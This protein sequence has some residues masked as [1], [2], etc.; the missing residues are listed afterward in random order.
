MIDNVVSNNLLDLM[1]KKKVT[2]SE[3]SDATGIAEITIN[4]LRNGHNVNP[5]LSTLMQ[6]SNYFGITVNELL[7]NNSNTLAIISEDGTEISQNMQINELNCN[8]DF[9]IKINHNNYSRFPKDTILFIRNQTKLRNGDYIVVKSNSNYI[10]CRVI[11]EPDAIL[12]ESL[13]RKEN[14]YKIELNNLS[15]VVIGALWLRN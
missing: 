11:I 2:I 7:G 13:S 4:K 14:I 12:G 3:L 8:A 1:K 5:T 9:A 15:G 6:L 10:I